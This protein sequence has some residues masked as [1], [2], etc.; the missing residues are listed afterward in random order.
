MATTPKKKKFDSTLSI[1]DKLTQVLM[2]LEYQY[3]SMLQE[4]LTEVFNTNKKDFAKFIDWLDSEDGEYFMNTSLLAGGDLLQTLFDRTKG[5]FETDVEN[6][7]AK[8]L[9][10]TASYMFD[11]GMDFVDY[12]WNE[13]NRYK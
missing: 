1:E 4:R 11:A 3:A 6:G 7:D 5:Q 9:E 8:K 10:E 13:Y 2:G 12:E